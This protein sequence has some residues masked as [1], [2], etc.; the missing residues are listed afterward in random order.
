MK[1]LLIF[2][3]LVLLTTPAVADSNSL[4]VMSYNIRCGLCE[5][6]DSPNHWS[7]RKFLI[8]HLIKIHNP[9]VVGLQE[10]E[11]FQAEDL[12]KMLEDYA[13]VGVGRD[14]GKKKGEANVILF[15]KSHFTLEQQKTLW[16]SPT[17]KKVSRGWD[18][19]Y[20]RTISILTLKNIHTGNT[21]N[22]FNTHFDHQGVM[23][24]QESATLLINELKKMP[25][26]IPLILTGD[27]NITANNKVYSSIIN[28][29]I[30]SD[31]E[32]TSLSKS[33]GGTVTYNDF[34]KTAEPD[35]KIDYVFTN[36]VVKVLSHHI[37]ATI[38]NNLYPS[39]HYPIIVELEMPGSENI[40]H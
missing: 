28:A 24:Q 36:K 17:P 3:T 29:G 26:T 7:K 6:A 18:A 12:V 34:G 35:K 40:T 27:F 32:Q 33:T 16:L 37:D 1:P 10:A 2:L 22:F 19:S 14:D 11:I 15:R 13:W 31:A 39:D 23:A 30:V 9:D 8:A 25:S 4:K 5:P 21:I 38:Y 20:N